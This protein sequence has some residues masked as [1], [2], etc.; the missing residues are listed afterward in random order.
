METKEPLNQ[1]QK[2]HK[3]LQERVERAREVQEKDAA[4]LK[5]KTEEEAVR[6]GFARA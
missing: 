4:I 1:F 5:K 3:R 6:E 2:V